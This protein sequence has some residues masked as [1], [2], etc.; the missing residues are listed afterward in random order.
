MKIIISEVQYRLLM[1]ENFKN[2]L[3]EK[4]E[5]FKNFTK[6]V[7]DDLKKTF[8]FNIK[9]GLTY[10][11]G[12]GVLLSHVNEFL[13]GKFPQLTDS[14]IKMLAITAIMIVFFETK[15]VIRNE[16]L[17]NKIEDLGLTNELANTINY[18]GG[19]KEK[20]SIILKSLDASIFRAVDIIGYTFLLPILNEMSK[21]MNA[22]DI[23][24]I[25][26]NSIA[27]SIAVATGVILSGHSLKKMFEK[28]SK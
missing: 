3:I 27:K 13:S 26:F 23:S 4:L 22:W 18:V 8:N 10:G 14:E 6:E 16:K 9:F 5:S 2:N 24:S 15:D 20:I 7:L 17:Q 1:E 19:L 21:F 25:D 11:A 28:L 12:I